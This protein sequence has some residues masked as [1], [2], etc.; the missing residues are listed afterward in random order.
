[1]NQFTINLAMGH[2]GQHSGTQP[3]GS[4]KSRFAGSQSGFTR[5]VWP[6]L[7]T[8][9]RAPVNTPQQQQNVQPGFSS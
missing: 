9:R 7:V 5:P 8:S 4:D 3:A 6:F 2:S 1:M